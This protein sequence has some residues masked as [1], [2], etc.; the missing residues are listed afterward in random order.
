MTLDELQAAIKEICEESQRGPQEIA[1]TY[2]SGV[3][4]WSLPQEKR[5]A[6]HDKIHS[7]FCQYRSQFFELAK[8]PVPSDDFWA[9]W[10]PEQ[11]EVYN[12]DCQAM[13]REIKDRDP[14][15]HRFLQRNALAFF[16]CSCGSREDSC[17][18]DGE[19]NVSTFVFTA[20]ASIFRIVEKKQ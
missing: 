6:A 2:A 18:E 13:E 16:T 20:D 9:S 7:L 14:E 11:V 12:R 19:G 8:V 10:T 15:L 5:K 3:S 1:Y 17:A 4:V